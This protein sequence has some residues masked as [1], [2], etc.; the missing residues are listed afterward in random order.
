MTGRTWLILIWVIA[1]SWAITAWAFA[2]LGIAFHW[3]TPLP[4]LAVACLASR[5]SRA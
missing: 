3:W 4:C 5:G 2:A 1:G